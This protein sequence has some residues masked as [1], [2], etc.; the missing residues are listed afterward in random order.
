MVLFDDKKAKVLGLSSLIIRSDKINVYFIT[1]VII[2]LTYAL[3]P[4]LYSVL[5][6]ILACKHIHFL[7]HTSK[8]VSIYTPF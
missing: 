6:N 3:S 5:G 8:G 1:T 7:S 2:I 4:K